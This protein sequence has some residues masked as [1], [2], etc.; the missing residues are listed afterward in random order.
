MSAPGGS[1]SR[2]SGPCRAAGSDQIDAV[3]DV[4]RRRSGAAGRDDQRTGVAELD[5]RRLHLV[6]FVGHG[7][8]DRM[9]GRGE[10]F[11]RHRDDTGATTVLVG[12]RCRPVGHGQD[13][14]GDGR[15]RAVSS[16]SPSVRVR[17]GPHSTSSRG[18]SCETTTTAVLRDLDQQVQ[19]PGGHGRIQRT[20]PFVAQQHER[21]ARQAGLRTSPAPGCR[22]FHPQG[23]RNRRRA[24]PRRAEGRCRVAGTSMTVSSAA[25]QLFPVGL[26]PNRVR[27]FH[28][29][30]DRMPTPGSARSLR[31]LQP[32]ART[33]PGARQQRRPLIAS[34][35]VFSVG[36]VPAGASVAS[37]E[38][39]G[40]RGCLVRP[41]RRRAPR[42]RHRSRL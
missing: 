19:D 12:S 13:A 17:M 24:R 25:L 2:P 3:R 11:G 1:S 34:P 14:G 8:S 32:R 4:P 30:S 28:P 31:R 21:W 35:R 6:A 42:T 10:C 16:R 36:A 15:T 9:P 27:W 37:G 41:A 23:T 26:T 18:R 39:G 40:R 33:S 29:T 38:I 22:L 7:V 5:Q 20:G